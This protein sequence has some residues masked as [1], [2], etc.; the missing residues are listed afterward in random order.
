M[1]AFWE[2]AWKMVQVISPALIRLLG[3]FVGGWMT[4]WRE[5]KSED[6]KV[7][8]ETAYLAAIV[9]GELD[10]FASGCADVVDDPGRVDDDGFRFQDV[11]RPKFDPSKFDV[12]WRSIPRVTCS[13]FL[14]C[15]IRLNSRTL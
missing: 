2:G 4:V 7:A 8:K 11:E 3:V 10:H 15:H 5:R 9:G 6:R 1:D 14:I 13:T 12:D